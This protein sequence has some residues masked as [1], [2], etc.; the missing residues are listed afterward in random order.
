[1]KITVTAQVGAQHVAFLNRMLRRAF[2]SLSRAAGPWTKRKTARARPPVIRELS[3]VLVND[4]QM[5]RL[6][7]DFM[8][9][10][11]PTDVLTFPIDTNPAGQV[12]SGE[13]YVCVPYARREAKACGVDIKHEVLLYALHG[14][15]H[16]LGYD[17][18]TAADFRAM[19]ALEDEILNEIGVGPVF[20]RNSMGG[21][22]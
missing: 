1:V 2:A 22:R 21:A 17:D 11:G 3:L 8:N 10:P 4:K 12:T 13:V 15:L 16:L 7:K 19:H 14:M 9:L 18:R 6:H 20:A 5:R